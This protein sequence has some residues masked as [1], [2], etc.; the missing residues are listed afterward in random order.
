MV[1]IEWSDEAQQAFIDEQ[2]VQFLRRVE[3]IDVACLFCCI[4]YVLRC[5]FL[6][7]T[8]HSVRTWDTGMRTLG[9]HVPQI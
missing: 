7:A 3:V 1:K 2:L 8:Q 6:Y 5:Q 9:K 4:R